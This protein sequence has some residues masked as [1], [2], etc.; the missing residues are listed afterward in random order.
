MRRWRRDDTNAT[1]LAREGAGA[2]EAGGVVVGYDCDGTAPVTARQRREERLDQRRAGGEGG[3]A[4]G[5]ETEREGGG[6]VGGTFG[7]VECDGIA[8]VT[9]RRG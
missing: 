5:R 8:P 2:G 6:G 4:D 9:A 7:D 3:S 1:E